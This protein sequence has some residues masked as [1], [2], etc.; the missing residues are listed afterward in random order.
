MII[1]RCA[2][3]LA[4]AA[5]AAGISRFVQAQEEKPRVALKEQ[6]IGSWK[7]K[8]G[9]DQIKITFTAEGKFTLE[10][11]GDADKG[12]W[13]LDAS[14]KPAKLDLNAEKQGTGYSIIEIGQDGKLRLT[15]PKKKAESRAKDFESKPNEVATL[16]K[17]DGTE[18]TLTKPEKPDPKAGDNLVGQWHGE[19]QG[20]KLHLIFKADGTFALT[21]GRDNNAPR[22]I[23]GEFKTDVSAWPYTLTLTPKGEESTRGEATASFAFDSASN[24]HMTEPT[25]NKDRIQ[26]DADEFE[27]VRKTVFQKADGDAPSTAE[28]KK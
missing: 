20:Q 1:Q 22:K 24:L 25:G 15:E 5:F 26:K 4:A 13:T 21:R 8:A 19:A 7:G 3:L 18:P 10:A 23:A 11:D 28:P 6:I 14:S 16:E 12:T 9:H 17:S 27:T 2:L